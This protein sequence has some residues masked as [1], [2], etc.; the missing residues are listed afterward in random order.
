ME[1]GIYLLTIKTQVPWAFTNKKDS[2]NCMMILSTYDT[3]PAQQEEQSIHILQGIPSNTHC[4]GAS[5]Y[6]NWG[7]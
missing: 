4:R 6:Y 5:N 2:R 7:T 1:G 3:S